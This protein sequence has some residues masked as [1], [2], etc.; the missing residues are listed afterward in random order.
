MRVVLRK[1]FA[2]FGCALFTICASGVAMAQGTPDPATAPAPEKETWNAPFGG[3][4][5]ASI[6][7]FTDYSY[8]GISQ[9]QREIA[10][11]GSFGYETPTVSEAVPLSA[12][13]GAWGSNV[14]YPGT[15]TAAEIDLLAG[16][17]LKTLQDKLTVDLGYIRYNYVGAPSNLFYDFNEFGLVAGY[18]FG[19]AQLSGALRYSPNFFA[20]A[21]NAWYKWVQVAMPMPFIKV[22][23]NVAFKAFASIGN[24]YVERFA[25]Y[26][27][28][29]DNYWDWQIGLTVNLYGIDLTAAYTDTNIDVAGCAN[30]QNCQGR[31]IFSVSKTF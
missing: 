29:T 26:A 21:G 12:Y 7:L 24:Q 25:N 10:V 16:L 11:Q 22:N 28:P 31:V 13:V 14:N 30:T 6:G 4:F 9:T 2:A 17:K 19:A 3:S 23:E 20:N 8:R 1:K 27:I 18:D 5:T 15:G